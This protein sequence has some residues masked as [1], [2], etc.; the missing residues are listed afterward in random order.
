[1]IN[2]SWRTNQ[3]SVFGYVVNDVLSNIEIASSVEIGIRTSEQEELDNNIVRSLKNEID[4]LTKIL[5]H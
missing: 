2:R 3:S 4:E 1:M 5:S